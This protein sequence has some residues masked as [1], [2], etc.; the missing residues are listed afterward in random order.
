MRRLAFA[1]LTSVFLGSVQ[2]SD[3]PPRSAADILALLDEQKPDPAKVEALKRVAAKAPPQTSDAVDLRHFY[4]ER[5]TAAGELGLVTQQLEDLRV[6]QKYTPQGQ[7]RFVLN[8]QLIGA[9]RQAGNYAEA[10]KLANQAPDNAVL[11]GARVGAWAQIAVF[12]AS[13][14]DRAGAQQAFERSVEAFQE[15]Q[16]GR[17]FPFLADNYRRIVEGTRATVL[18]AE[19]KYAEAEAAFRLAMAYGDSFIANH[20]VAA[21]SV[22]STMPPLL[23]RHRQLVRMEAIGLANTQLQQG[24]FAEAE[25]SARNAVRRALAFFGKYSPD[26]G[27]AVASLA[28]II[29]EQGRFHDAAALYAATVDIY[30]RIGAAPYAPTLVNAL[31]GLGD[32]LVQE[33]KYAEADAVY[34]RVRK[35]LDLSP[36][37]QAY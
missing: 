3:A 4:T 36:E 12:R 32:T 30:E 24:K 18:R 25:I 35:G 13:T 31:K 8:T 2:A 22:P 34:R 9:E 33:A 5:A 11:P 37:S 19:G 17:Y 6:A 20:A 15:A 10:V 14:G 16:G 28:H 26:T 1:F 23:D 29:F 7:E 21:R 27:T